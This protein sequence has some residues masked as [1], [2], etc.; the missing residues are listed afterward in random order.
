LI[1]IPRYSYFGAAWVTIYSETIIAFASAFIV[2]KYSRFVPDMTVLLK[3]L[4][5][6]LLMSAS[7]IYTKNQNIFLVLVIASSVYLISLY[8]IKGID[9]QDLLNLIA[10]D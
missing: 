1:F 5:A 6:S 10:K 8:L 4:I 7:L 3:S 9:K 2:W